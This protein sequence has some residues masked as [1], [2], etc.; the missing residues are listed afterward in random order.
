MDRKPYPTDLTDEQW[1]VLEPLLER[2]AGPGRPPRVDLREIVNALLY[3]ARAGCQWRLLPHDFPDWTAVRY[4]FDVWTQDGTWEAVNRRLVELARQ[5]R[6][7]RAQ[8]TAAIID[9]QSVKTTE[10]GGERGVDGGKKDPGSQAAFPRGHRGA[11]LGGPGGS[12]EPGRPGRRTLDAELGQQPL[13]QAAEA[14][15]RSR[16]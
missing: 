11:S 1:R 9:S 6:R 8:P 14:V 4:Y 7:R 13:A 15:G 2:P 10:A 3:Q 5:K 12:R 16:V